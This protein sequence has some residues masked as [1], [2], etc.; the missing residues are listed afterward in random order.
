MSHQYKLPI[1]TVVEEVPSGF[2][3][4]IIGHSISSLHR[5]PTP[6]YDLVRC[7]S[8][9]LEYWRRTGYVCSVVDTWP[10]I[11]HVE[12]GLKVCTANKYVGRDKR[13]IRFL[14]QRVS[15]DTAEI[16]TLKAKLKV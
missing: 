10:V 13:R 5:N 16:Q 8:T 2:F 14:E 1:G 12:A 6:T 11:T 7:T 15:N 4:K 3:F 9:G